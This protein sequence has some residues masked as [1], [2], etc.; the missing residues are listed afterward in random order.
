MTNFEPPRTAQV[1]LTAPT[2]PGAYH[3]IFAFA[4]E[5]KGDQVA[6]A[7]NWALGHDVWNDGNDIARVNDAQLAEAQA[8]GYTSINWLGTSGYSSQYVPVDA[9]TIEVTANG[10][11]KPVIQFTNIPPTQSV[12][13]A[14]S[15]RDVPLARYLVWSVAGLVIIGMAMIIFRAITPRHSNDDGSNPT[16]S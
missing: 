13:N 2:E 9:L 8:S 16:E 10:G 7:S 5:R 1:S 6:S 14:K 12:K 4:W 3:V 11:E 15:H